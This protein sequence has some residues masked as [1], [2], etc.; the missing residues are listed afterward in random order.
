MMHSK[1]ALEILRVHGH[2]VSFL[3]LPLLAVNWNI[4]TFCQSCAEECR[5]KSWC[6]SFSAH[7]VRVLGD[8]TNRSCLL[9]DVG[10]DNIR[11]PEDLVVVVDNE[12]VTIINTLVAQLSHRTLAGTFTDLCWGSLVTLL[13]TGTEYIGV[14]MGVRE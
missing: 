7:V 10:V 8:D 6:L 11:D 2:V 4:C 9:S 13:E 12:I 5:D 14:S 1:S 3:T